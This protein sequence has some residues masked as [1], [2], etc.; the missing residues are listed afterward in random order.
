[1][2]KKAKWVLESG[3]KKVRSRFS[4]RWKYLV[5]ESGKGDKFVKIA[6]RRFGWKWGLEG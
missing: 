2:F 6:D 3:R 1:M 5:L 4:F